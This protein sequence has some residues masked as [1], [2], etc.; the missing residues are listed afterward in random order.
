MSLQ[1]FFKSVCHV[2]THVLLQVSCVLGHLS[3]EGWDNAEDIF[4]V[5]EHIFGLIFLVELP[6]Q[7]LTNSYMPV[8]S[9]SKP[10]LKKVHI[11]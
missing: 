10:C 6:T 8:S 5:V 2:L 7:L 9:L 1:I 4:F 11:P 3:D